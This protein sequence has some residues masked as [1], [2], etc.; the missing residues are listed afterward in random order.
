MSSKAGYYLV[1]IRWRFHL[2]DWPRILALS[3]KMLNN[4][5]IQF[6]QDIYSV[7]IDKKYLNSLIIGYEEHKLE[8]ETPEFIQKTQH[9]KQKEKIDSKMIDDMIE[10]VAIKGGYK[11]NV[12]EQKKPENGITMKQKNSDLNLDR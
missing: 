5:D 8:K 9:T 12:C 4:K 6:S 2:G 3:P 11:K 10:K 1:I 7:E